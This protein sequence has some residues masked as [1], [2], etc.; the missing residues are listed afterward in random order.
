MP[1][2]EFDTVALVTV[3]ENQDAF[4][5]ALADEQH[6]EGAFLM[7]QCSLTP[8]SASDIA[9]GLDSYCLLDDAGAIK[10]GGV[11]RAALDGARLTLV[12]TDEAAEEFGVEDG[13]NTITLTVPTEDVGRLAGG[14]HRVFTYGNPDK[15]PQ[16]SGI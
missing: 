12:L 3:E 11:T 8:P 10:Y 6:G 16:I 13:T 9:T 7:F 4:V 1:S 5:V 15:Q 2:P 14:L